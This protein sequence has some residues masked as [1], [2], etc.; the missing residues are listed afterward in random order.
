MNAIGEYWQILGKRL[1][2]DVS[3]QASASEDFS[4][5]ATQALKDLPPPRMT[6][7]DIAQWIAEV[8]A[9][10]E[11]VNFFFGFGEPPLV[12]YQTPRFYVEVLFWFPSPTSIHGHAFT[13]AFVVL[14]G[15]SIEV[16][17]DFQVESEPEEAVQLGRLIPRELEFIGPGRVHAI[18]GGADHVHSVTHLGNPSLTLVVRTPGRGDPRQYRYHR[19]GFA[20]C[21][22]HHHRELQRRAAVFAALWRASPPR[23]LSVLI[24][25]LSGANDHSFYSVLEPLL[26]KLPPPF[27]ENELLPLLMRHFAARR[28]PLGALEEVFRSRKLW[29]TVRTLPNVPAEAQIQVALADSFPTVAERD[30]MLRKSYGEGAEAMPEQWRRLITGLASV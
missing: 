16:S 18:P 21:S 14:D 28:A 8:P 7:A 13:G 2:A 3:A 27:I 6:A 11:Q 10:P 15:F 26:R 4:V 17:Y 23:F 19:S 24:E 22:N 1:E 29:A 5:I 30:A 20:A 25:Y 9:L 12:V